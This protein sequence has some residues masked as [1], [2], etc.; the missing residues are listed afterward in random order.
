MSCWSSRTGRSRAGRRSSRVIAVVLALF[1]TASC[2]GAPGSRPPSSIPG[3]AVSSP[4]PTVVSP[5]ASPHGGRPYPNESRYTD[6]LER[7]A[8]RSAYSQCR[9]LS[10]EKMAE[11]YG[12]DAD[13][14]P[15]VAQAY[16]EATFPDS[17]D[18]RE[19]TFRGCLDA[20]EQGTG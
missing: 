4:F 8:Y 12:G 18:H 11:A 20:F 3:P 19:A 17:A 5:S 15:L 13:R 16:A 10:I 7:Y 6:P 14:P 9:F 1:S 2:A